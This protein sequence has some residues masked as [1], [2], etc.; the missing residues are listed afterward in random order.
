M[1]WFRNM[2]MNQT[3]KLILFQ[4]YPYLGHKNKKYRIVH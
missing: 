2:K 4:E 3:P 1:Y